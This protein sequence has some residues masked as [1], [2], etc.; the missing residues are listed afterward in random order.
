VGIF[1]SLR[2]FYFVSSPFFQYLQRTMRLK[3]EKNIELLFKEGRSLF[4]F[5]IKAVFYFSSMPGKNFN[6]GVSVTK[7]N[8][9]KAVDRNRIKRQLRE[10]V[11]LDADVFCEKKVN[12]SIMYIYVAKERLEHK[13]I[14]SAISKLN[15]KLCFLN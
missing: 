4:V 3:G 2:I 5:P 8:F 11:R 14:Q 10:I 1:A 6:F 15:K 7:R 12:V 9:K 13:M